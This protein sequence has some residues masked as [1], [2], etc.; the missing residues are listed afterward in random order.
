[1]FQKEVLDPDWAY[2]FFHIIV[3]IFLNEEMF[4]NYVNKS[5]FELPRSW[6][7]TVVTD[8]YEPLNSPDSMCSVVLKI[9]TRMEA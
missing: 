8:R 3:S 1:M 6:E 2:V 9:N 4:F 7:F 5:R